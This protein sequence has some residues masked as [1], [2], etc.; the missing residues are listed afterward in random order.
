MNS[1]NNKIKSVGV[2]DTHLTVEL[3]DGRSIRLPL[4][5]FPTLAEATARQR[6]KWELCG[7]D[8]GIH[9]PPLNYDLSVAGLLRGEPEAPGIRRVKKTVKYPAHKSG[10]AYALAEEAEGRAGS[11]LPADGTQTEDGAH[12]LSRHSSATAE[13]TRPTQRPSSL[14]DTRVIYCGDNLEQLKKPHDS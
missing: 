2:N 1:L 9:W 7:A 12:G 14:V 5:L 10:K 4:T 3:L 11:P 13:A 8:T 6:A